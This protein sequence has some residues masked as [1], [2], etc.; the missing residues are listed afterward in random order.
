V[1]ALVITA[2]RIP[3]KALQPQS[4]PFSVNKGRVSWLPTLLDALFHIPTH[5]DAPACAS[6][7]L[8][9]CTSCFIRAASMSSR[10]LPSISSTVVGR[11]SCT[12]T[13]THAQ[14]LLVLAQA[15]E[16]CE[17]QRDCARKQRTTVF[18]YP[19]YPWLPGSREAQAPSERALRCTFIAGGGTQGLPAARKRA[20]LACSC[21]AA[22]PLAAGGARC[23]S[24]QQQPQGVRLP[25]GKVTAHLLGQRKQV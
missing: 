12:R 8:A 14:T 9:R 23:P 1:V 5:E 3:S 25:P 20:K 7:S 22:Q 18:A 17:R 19:T 21:A 2:W 10:R 4:P 13:H 16:R 11:N 24:W 15:G 6:R